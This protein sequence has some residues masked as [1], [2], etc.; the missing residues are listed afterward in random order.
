MVNPFVSRANSNR[1]RGRQVLH[2]PRLPSPH[3]P[4]WPNLP[5][6]P[7]NITAHLPPR[8]PPHLLPPLPP[9][10]PS[11]SLL[12]LP[13]TLHLPRHQI[14]PNSVRTFSRSVTARF[15][16]VSGST[17]R[18]GNDGVNEWLVGM[19]TRLKFIGFCAFSEPA[20]IVLNLK[21]M[22]PRPLHP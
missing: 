8:L 10:P 20:I 18:G 6:P 3:L 4:H 21:S 1:T 2:Q 11:R 14:S 7:L 19:G 12:P 5:F 17:A 9:A 16:I 15:R 22:Q 13:H